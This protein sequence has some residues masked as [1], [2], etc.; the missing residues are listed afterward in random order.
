MQLRNL[1]ADE[2]LGNLQA[3]HPYQGIVVKDC[4]LFIVLYDAG[5]VTYTCTTR[6][7]TCEGT[8]VVRGLCCSLS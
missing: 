8:T 2:E 4:W 3:V 5:I 6:T 7:N 1:D